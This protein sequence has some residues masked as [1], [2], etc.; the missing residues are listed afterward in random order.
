M[1][2]QFAIQQEHQQCLQAGVARREITPFWGVELTGWGYY[3][4]RRWQR[5]HDPLLCDCLVVAM[6]N[7]GQQIG[8]AARARSDADRRSI[9]RADARVITAATGIPGAG[10]PAYLLAQPQRAGGRGIAR[11]RR[12]RPVLRRVGQQ[13]SGDGGDPGLATARAGDAFPT[14]DRCAGHQLQPHAS[15]KAWSIRG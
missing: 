12:V 6:A 11:R 5:I 3:I 15:P 14:L 7:D 9:H 4:E 1:D 2:A 13:A 8:R 10:D